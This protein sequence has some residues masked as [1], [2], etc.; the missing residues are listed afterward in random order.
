LE[1][2][3]TRRTRRGA[4]AIR[5]GDFAL[6]PLVPS[7][8]AL[9]PRDPRLFWATEERS[10]PAVELGH[11]NC[12]GWTFPEGTTRSAPWIRVTPLYA[13]GS[14]G[15]TS[16]HFA[17]PAAP[18]AATH[19]PEPA[20][21]F[22]SPPPAAGSVLGAGAGLALA[23]AA[24]LG[25]DIAVASRRGRLRRVLLVPFFAAVVIGVL[26][27]LVERTDYPA[28]LVMVAAAAA[29]LAIASHFIARRRT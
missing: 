21:E 29:A 5:R 2:G 24:I 14:E 26:A 3:T 15:R 23:A 17:L 25:L 9:F 27:G 20:A 13:D 11:A 7:H 19:E 6:D 12:L 28:W 4:R 1:R 18:P 22:V 10:A 8:T 16:D